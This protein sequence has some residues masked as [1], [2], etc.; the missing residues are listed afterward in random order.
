MLHTETVEPST[1]DLLKSNL[2]EY[3]E[4]DHRYDPGVRSKGEWIAV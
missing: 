4:E 2:G 3:T 1:L